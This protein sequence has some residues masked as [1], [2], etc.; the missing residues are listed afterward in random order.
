MS[1]NCTAGKL[2]QEGQVFILSVYIVR[3]WKGDY[4]RV[5][6]VAEEDFDYEL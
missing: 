4:A 5:L 2:S 3:L 1:V 6:L